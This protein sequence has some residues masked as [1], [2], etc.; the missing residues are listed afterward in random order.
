MDL[1]GHILQVGIC[2][3]NFTINKYPLV[4]HEAMETCYFM[5]LA[6]MRLISKKETLY[7]LNTLFFPQHFNGELISTTVDDKK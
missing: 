1:I 2:V 7:Y 3:Q 5:H 6:E 4:Y